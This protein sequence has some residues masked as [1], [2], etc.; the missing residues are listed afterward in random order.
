M[1]KNSDKALWDKQIKPNKQ[2]SQMPLYF[3]VRF[4]FLLAIFS[5]AWVLALRVI[6]IPNKIQL[7]KINFT[8]A[9]GYKLEIAFGLGMWASVYFPLSAL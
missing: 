1:E 8:L 2:A 6:C 4:I 9:S 3:W 7:E 5:K